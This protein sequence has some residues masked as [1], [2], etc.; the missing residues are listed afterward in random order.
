M[1]LHTYETVKDAVLYR[2]LIDRISQI[3]G[4]SGFMP[5]GGAKLPQTQINQII[6]WQ[7]ED[8]PL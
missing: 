7:N 6:E 3:E 4:Q 5:L 8:F 2:G 1:S